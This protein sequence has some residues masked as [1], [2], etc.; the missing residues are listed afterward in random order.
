MASSASTS[1]RCSAPGGILLV[2]V[3]S[4]LLYQLKPVFQA[5]FQCIEKPQNTAQL[6]KSVYRLIVTVIVATFPCRILDD[7]YKTC[8]PVKCLI[9]CTKTITA[10]KSFVERT[11]IYFAKFFREYATDFKRILYADCLTTKSLSSLF[12]VVH[13]SETPRYVALSTLFLLCTPSA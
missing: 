7:L 12:I 11:T 5:Q 2:N 1:R 6:S 4:H 10:V 13:T 9:K 3:I 8:Y